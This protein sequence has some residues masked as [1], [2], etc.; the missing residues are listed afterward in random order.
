MRRI[1]LAAFD[2]NNLLVQHS[3]AALD[4][5]RPHYPKTCNLIVRLEWTTVEDSTNRAYQYWASRNSKPT[6]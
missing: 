1:W 4:P 6:L 2:N 5:T 3:L